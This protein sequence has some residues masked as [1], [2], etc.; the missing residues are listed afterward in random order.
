MIGPPILTPGGELTPYGERVAEERH[1]DRLWGR[2]EDDGGHRFDEM[3]PDLI[4]GTNV[5]RF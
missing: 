5:V 3:G 1:D 4:P 2:D